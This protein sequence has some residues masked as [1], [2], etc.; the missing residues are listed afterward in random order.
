[1]IKANF[2]THTT[3]CDG[4]DS[5]ETMVLAAI[6]RG[7]TDIGFSPHMSFPLAHEWELG[8]EEAEAYVCEIRELKRKYASKI[9]VWCGGEADYI[10]GVTT[11]EKS[12]YAALGLDYLIGSIHTIAAP[13]GGFVHVDASPKSLE[14]GLRDNFGGDG[15]LLIRSYFEQ[16]REM[17]VYDFDVLGHPDLLRKFNVKHPYFD[18][19]AAWYREELVRTAD[20]IAASGKIVEVNTGAISRG[21]LDDAYPSPEFR[22]LLRERGVKFILSSDSHAAETIDCGFGRFGTQEEYLRDNH[23]LSS[24]CSDIN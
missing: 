9:N 10:R 13:G 8:P 6:E 3:W 21:W 4:K 20:A 18:E 2:H 14:D 16:L 19:S 12:R 17:L 22:A 15:E 5:A 24:C 7:F 1:M 11:P 23:L